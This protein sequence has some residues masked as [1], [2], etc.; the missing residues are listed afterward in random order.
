MSLSEGIVQVKR[1]RERETEREREVRREITHRDTVLLVRSYS[2]RSQNNFVVI[3]LPASLTA[4][5]SIGNNTS[6]VATAEISAR[7]ISS[8]EVLLEGVLF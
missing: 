4:C 5:S 6:H 3:W 8:A 1:E 2:G 7:N